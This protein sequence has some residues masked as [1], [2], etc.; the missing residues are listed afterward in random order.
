MVCTQFRQPAPDIMQ[1][2]EFFEIKIIASKSPYNRPT[3]SPLQYQDQDISRHYHS[4]LAT[5]VQINNRRTLLQQP[6]ATDKSESRKTLEPIK[7]K[8]WAS[9]IKP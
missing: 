2:G 1:P 4:S 5:R 9:R 8:Q 6:V 3:F 7:T